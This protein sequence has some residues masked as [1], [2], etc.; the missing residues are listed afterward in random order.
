MVTVSAAK[1]TPDGL[2]VPAV[3]QLPVA[4]DIFAAALAEE[5]PNNKMRLTNET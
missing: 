2:Q 4:S 1:G 5:I 3:F